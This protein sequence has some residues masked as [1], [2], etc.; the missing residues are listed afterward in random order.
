MG[1]FNYIDFVTTQKHKLNDEFI[2]NLV[3]EHFIKDYLNNN[4]IIL[5]G[6]LDEGIVDFVKKVKN[7]IKDS[8]TLKDFAK[9]IDTL[10][11]TR[12][13]KATIE[14]I[15]LLKQ[16]GVNIKN[17]KDVL[18]MLVLMLGKKLNLNELKTTVPSEKIANAEKIRYKFKNLYDRA[19]EIINK[20]FRPKNIA[21]TLAAAI[22]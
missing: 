7:K 15:N 8:K 16:M 3:L 11:Q 6:Q 22:L 14:F 12:R 17:Q 4:N 18:A 5:E 13:P 10:K 9:L 2:T 1:N 20:G 19:S 21:L